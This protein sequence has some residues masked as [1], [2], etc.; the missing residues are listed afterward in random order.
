MADAGD[1]MMARGE[2]LF[3]ANGRE[4]R[5][6]F[7]NRAL[8]RAEADTGRSVVAL[9]RRLVDGDVS[10]A[11]VAHLLHRGLEGAGQSATLDDAYDIMDGVGFAC[12]A[13][14]VLEAFADVLRGDETNP[15]AQTP[16]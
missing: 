13:P 15:P 1:L 5:I 6:L 4:M 8:A 9:L 2:R 14:L 16:S 12:I 11:D 7:T 10:I 3:T